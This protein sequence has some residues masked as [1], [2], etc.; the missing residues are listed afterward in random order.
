MHRVGLGEPDVPINAR[1]LI[2]PAVAQ[3]RVHA[4]HDAVL[5]AIG[6]KV[7]DVE[8]ERSVA[9]VIAADEAAIHEDDDASEGAVELHREAAA[10]V[11]GGNFESRRYQPTLVSG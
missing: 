8:L 5:A 1:A 10:L 11:A 4:Q 7:G 9:V 6:E 3:A 2:E